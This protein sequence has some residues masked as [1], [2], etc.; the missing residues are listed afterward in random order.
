MCD[1]GPSVSLPSFDQVVDYGRQAINAGTG[2]LINIDNHGN[3]GLGR[4]SQN[5]VSLGTA[6]TVQI[7]R[8]GNTSDGFVTRGFHDAGQWIEQA[9]HDTGHF[10]ERG[11]REG[12]ESL[13]GVAIRRQMTEQSN[14]ALKQ[15]GEQR[16]KQ[17]SDSNYRA[18]MNDRQS[19]NLANR[20]KGTPT[21]KQTLGG[22]GFSSNTFLGL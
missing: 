20:G 19:S 10:V 3:T 4:N 14:A 1:D 22:G 13:T 21:T 5:L 7:D 18:M 15:A 17:I 6:G 2:D 12:A 9:A 11:V 16:D 8:R